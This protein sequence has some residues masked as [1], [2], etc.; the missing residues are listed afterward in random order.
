MSRNARYSGLLDILKFAQT[1]AGN[2]SQ[3]ITALEGANAWLA[4]NVE[5]EQ[6][7]ELANTAIEANIPRIIFTTTV[8]EEE[9]QQQFVQTTYGPLLALSKEKGL[10]MTIIRHGEVVDGD[11]DY[12]YQIVNASTPLVEMSVPRGVLGRIATELIRLKDS[13]NQQCGL[14]SSGEFAEAYLELLRSSGLT[15][16][17]EVFKVYT[18]GMDVVYQKTEASRRKR[19][20]E[21]KERNELQ[22]ERRLEREAEERAANIRQQELAAAA[23]SEQKGEV[24]KSLPST[25]RATRS[26]GLSTTDGRTTKPRV[27]SKYYDDDDE[28]DDEILF[29]QREKKTIEQRI[30]ERADQIL[31]EIYHTY[32]T[33]LVT[34]RT[35]KQEFFNLNNVKAIALA[36]K[37]IEEEDAKAIEQ[38]IQRQVDLSAMDRVFDLE[39][40]QYAKLMQLERK[41]MQQQKDASDIW[42]KYIYLLI[43][44]TMDDCAKKNILFHNL[45]EFQQ[46][47]LL[48]GHANDLRAMVNLPPYEVVYDALDAKIIVDF[49]SSQ[50]TESLTKKFK[51]QR[52]ADEIL[53]DLNTKYGKMLKNVT[54]LRGATQIIELA[55]ETLRKELPPPPPK[56]QEIRLR[57]SK[58]SQRKMNDLRLG[59]I[60]NRLTPFAGKE[61]AVGRL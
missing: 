18:G 10:A 26:G 44:V 15:R 41:E 60:R 19:E 54:A 57:E 29:V 48:R 38:E 21:E 40:R 59:K 9:E 24:V 51:M 4:F 42:V 31:E 45:D 11:E 53:I 46:T 6:F 8:T 12:P 22:E 36:T 16:R 39:S 30:E 34:K 17:Q 35:E 23:A 61:E 25:Y 55:I 14:S 52:N 28:E 32:N 13:L 50:P 56:P 37:E 3:L 2:S 49:F 27:S 20:Q 43:E 47:L 5:K 7:V 1:D 58:E 33:R